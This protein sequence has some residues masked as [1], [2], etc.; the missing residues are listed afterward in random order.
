MPTAL[1]IGWWSRQTDRRGIFMAE[2]GIAVT[3]LFSVKPE[4][5]ETFCGN[6]AMFVEDTASVPGFRDIE[7]VRSNDEAHHVTIFEHW[8]D[9]ASLEKYVPWRTDRGANGPMQETRH[10]PTGTQ[11]WPIGV[12]NVSDGEGVGQR[13]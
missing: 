9:L 12:E 1:C 4:F 11:D 10:T 5:S 8:D 3:V 13:G 7:I 6:L 2:N